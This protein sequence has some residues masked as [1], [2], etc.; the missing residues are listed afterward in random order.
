MKVYRLV[1]VLVAGLGTAYCAGGG[2]T[3]TSSSGTPSVTAFTINIVGTD[4]GQL[5]F[6][7]NPAGAG[8]QNVVFK[9]AT[10]DV[11]RVVLN[12]G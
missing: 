6:S 12:D 11:H 5:S 8:G 4:K 10:A 7:P 1:A 9:N 3:P 2:S